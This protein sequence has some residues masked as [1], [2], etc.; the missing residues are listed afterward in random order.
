M[1]LLYDADGD[2]ITLPSFTP[3]AAHTVI[4]AVYLTNDTARQ[5]LFTHL[6]VDWKMPFRGDNVGD[7]FQYFHAGATYG[8]AGAS[9]ANFANYGLNKWLYI[10]YRSSTSYAATIYIGDDAN[11]PAGPSSYDNVAS[12]TVVTPDTTAGT[13]HVG[14]NFVTTR[15]ARGRIGFYGVWNVVMN[16]TEVGQ[17]WANPSSSFMSANL[18]VYGRPGLN[19]T[20]DVPDESGNSLTG[21]ITALSSPDYSPAKF[22][23]YAARVLASYR[24]RRT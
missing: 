15:W 18:V 24:R 16:D 14:N 2:L 19:G 4:I 17:F 12:Q 7:P 10:V 9:A 23:A 5:G 8:Q 11:T 21:A 20:T 22:F 6:G 13:A 1:S 3:P